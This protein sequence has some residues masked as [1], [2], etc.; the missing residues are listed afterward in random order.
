[1]RFRVSIASADRSHP[2]TS[3]QKRARWRQHRQRRVNMATDQTRPSASP[4]TASV[5]VSVILKTRVFASAS[6][7]SRAHRNRWAEQIRHVL[8]RLLKPR[9]FASA[10]QPTSRQHCN[11]AHRSRANVAHIRQSRPDSGLGFQGKP[12]KTF[13]VV[14]SSPGGGWWRALELVF[15]WRGC[16]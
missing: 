4:E 12:H 3:S 5:R 14:P 6:F 13:Q 15:G 8:L 2:P 7:A 16:V 9:A 1:M 10:S 11:R